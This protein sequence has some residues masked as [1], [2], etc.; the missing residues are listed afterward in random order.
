M[1][2]LPHKCCQVAGTWMGRRWLTWSW[3]IYPLCGHGDITSM[4][5]EWKKLAW[6]QALHFIST[7]KALEPPYFGAL[8]ISG[9]FTTHFLTNF[10]RF[11]QVRTAEDPAK[12][13]G[14][15]RVQSQGSDKD[16]GGATCKQCSIQSQTIL[17]LSDKVFLLCA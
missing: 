16:S 12:A 7:V 17:A 10:I 13:E 6:W 1:T 14:T 3:T 15:R 11:V 8:G 4:V 2:A 5:I 9:G